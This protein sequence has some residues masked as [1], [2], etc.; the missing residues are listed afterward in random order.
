M[1]NQKFFLRQSF[2][3]VSIILAAALN[4]LKSEAAD[5]DAAP[6]ESPGQGLFELIDA[7]K[8]SKEDKETLKAGLSVAIP[9][10][11]TNESILGHVSQAT[12]DTQV[13][14]SQGNYANTL[15]LIFGVAQHIEHKSTEFMKSDTFQRIPVTDREVVVAYFGEVAEYYR[16]R[17]LETLFAHDGLIFSAPAGISPSITNAEYRNLLYLAAKTPQPKNR[18]RLTSGQKSYVLQKGDSLAFIARKHKLSPEAI[19]AAN[20]GL[21]PTRM[22]P[23]QVIVIPSL[24]GV[25]A[26]VPPLTKETALSSTR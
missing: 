10:A 5:V 7:A 17:A 20:P 23:G 14:K 22:Q 21:N 25:T 8:Y 15:A 18:V 11:T 4:G 2:I 13:K 9:A 24:A 1:R 26:T 6:A 12:I 3:T 19:L 16:A